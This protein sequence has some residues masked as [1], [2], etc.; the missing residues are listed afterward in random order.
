MRGYTKCGNSNQNIIRSFEG[1]NQTEKTRQRIQRKP[2]E[3]VRVVGPLAITSSNNVN[4]S[5]AS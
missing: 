3:K 4:V 5:R 1:N 2:T